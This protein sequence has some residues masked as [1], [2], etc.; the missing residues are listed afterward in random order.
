M[1]HHSSPARPR[2]ELYMTNTISEDLSKDVSQEQ[3]IPASF[4]GG[5]PPPFDGTSYIPNPRT[6]QEDQ[7]NQDYSLLML[8]ERENVARQYKMAVSKGSRYQ[9]VLEPDI[10]VPSFGPSVVNNQ[11]MPGP[12]LPGPVPYQYSQD[13]VYER[14]APHGSARHRIQSP[15][16]VE[17]YDMDPQY[18]NT[19]RSDTYTPHSQGSVSL[20]EAN[21]LKAQ[22]AALRDKVRELEGKPALPIASKYQILYRIE[23][24]GTYPSDNHM[25]DSDGGFN[26]R[27]RERRPRSRSRSWSRSPW[28]G[29]YTDPPELIQ[30]NMG[31]PYLR[32]N[33]SLVNFELYLALNRDIS[34]V[35]FR[36]YKRRA[37]RQSSNTKYGKPEPF[38]ETIFPV[39]EDL[40]DVIADFLRG[41]EFQSMQNNYRDKGEVPS[42][43]LFV[44]HN[45][46][47]GESE[48]KGGL[49][50]EAQ[51]QFDLFMDYVQEACGKE[52]T[53]ADLLFEKGKIRPEY[54]QY[55]FKPNQIL[56]SHQNKEHIGFVARD[57]PSQSPDIDGTSNA[58]WWISAQTWD[59][60][61]DFYKY[62]TRLSFEMPKPQRAMEMPSSPEVEYLSYDSSLPL[63]NSDIDKECAITDLAVFPIKYAPDFL[64]QKLQRRGEIF[65]TF[66]TQKHV[67]YQATEE[68]NFQTM[69]DDRYII[70][71][72][73]YKRLHPD[74]TGYLRD[75]PRKDTLD[76]RAMARDQPPP[77]PFSMLMPPRVTGF[78]LRRKKWFDLSVDRISHVEWN[79]DAFDSLAIDSKSRD[80]IEALVTNYV[81]P[82]YSADL[83]AG[84]GNGLILLLH[85][86]PGTGKTLTAESVAEIAERPLYRVT[87]GDVGTKPEEVEK[88]LES[89]LHLGKIWNCVVLLD[90][91]DVFLEQRGLE[92]LNRNALVSAFLRV[93]EYFEGILILTTNRVGTFDEAFKSRIQLALHYP[94][95]GEEQRRIIWNTFIKRL[96]GFD[97]DAI[98]VKNLTGSLDVLQR[99]K[100]NGRQIRNAITTARQY[101]KWKREVLTYDHLKDVIEVSAK[102]DDYLENIHRG[103]IMQF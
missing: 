54:V 34:F 25:D 26:P 83:I 65:W 69:A 98:D 64:I 2:D 17:S 59:F 90:E 91:A 43:Y 27:H 1:Y 76:D 50:S 78:N 44:Y 81:E 72:K 6:K 4:G 5:P 24:D 71:M 29:I 33:D 79:K 46:G 36:N 100:L 75:T 74:T 86:G 32:C 57:W 92:D 18:S 97:E 67:S 49:S 88:Y 62:R 56:V 101:A 9:T 39:S 51:R 48:I 30:R 11:N 35:V 85:G 73:T 38:S 63:T 13:P 102:F 93:V 28:M 61:G 95:L 42:P 55:L 23:K 94:P 80:L 22:I 45:R 41:K 70:D 87:C 82:E 10:P 89:V 12:F 84:K 53:A 14:N 7:N 68:E 96:D 58:C 52:Y 40:K 31:A 3:P 66:R 99:E 19:V 37:E 103:G 15:Q 8:Q 20:S 47:G 16:S 60:D 77:E 21:D